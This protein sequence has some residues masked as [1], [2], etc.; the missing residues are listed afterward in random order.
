MAFEKWPLRGLGLKLLDLPRQVAYYRR[1]G[2]RLLESD[3]NHAVLGFEE[4]PRREEPRHD[5]RNARAW[6]LP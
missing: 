4:E 1:L 2:L 5:E 3:A 6:L